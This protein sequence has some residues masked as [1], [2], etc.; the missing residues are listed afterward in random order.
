MNVLSIWLLCV[1]M[2]CVDKKNVEN[3]YIFD[4]A[5]GHVERVGKKLQ[6]SFRKLSGKVFIHLR[7]NSTHFLFTLFFVF[8]IFYAIKLYHRVNSNWVNEIM[9]EQWMRWLNLQS[10]STSYCRFFLKSWKNL[11]NSTIFLVLHVS[12]TM[13]N[14]EQKKNL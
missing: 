4:W 12:W 1:V 8:Y 10:S 14:R 7:S 11:H 9:I 2:W 6:F 13:L 5:R 3:I